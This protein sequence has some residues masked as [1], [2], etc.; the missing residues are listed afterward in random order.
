MKQ[1]KDSIEFN[2]DALYQSGYDLGWNSAISELEALM[3][4]LGPRRKAM[5]EGLLVE[6]RSAND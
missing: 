2:L 4:S 1:I 3:E 6:M 5:L